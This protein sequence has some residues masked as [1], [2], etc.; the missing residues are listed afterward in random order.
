[1]EKQ[2]YSGEHCESPKLDARLSLIRAG[3]ELFG[4][5]GLQ[6]TSTRMISGAAGINISAISYYFGSKDGLY[7]A[8]IEHI[9]EGMSERMNPLRAEVETIFDNGVPSKKDAESA[10]VYLLR[11]FAGMFILSKDF[12]LWAKILMREQINP[13][14]AFDVLYKEHIRPLQQLVLQLLAAYTGLAPVGDALKLRAHAF[15]GQVLGFF[16][17]REAV[18]RLLGVSQLEPQHIELIYSIITMH[19]K[20]SLQAVAEMEKTV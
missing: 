19:T 9:I 18:L 2:N 17:G 7:L 1:M 14:P 6:A 15:L 20:A 3:L 12:S 5:H 13:S 8:V 10:L 16:V 4:E 11:G